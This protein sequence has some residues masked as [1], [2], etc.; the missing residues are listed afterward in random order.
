MPSHQTSPSSVLAQLV[1]TV[2]CSSIFRAFGLVCSPVPGATPKKPASGLTA[3]SRPSEP[4]FIHA[5]SSP[6]VSTFHPGRVGDHHRQVGLAACAG[7]RAGD[8]LRLALGRG[9]LE[10]QH[11][12]RE[13]ALVAR[14]DRGDPQCEALLAEQRVATVSRP[15][16][17][18]L[19]GLRE[20]HDVFVLGVA[21]PRHVLLAVGQRCA[22]GVQT[23]H[24][25]AIVAEHV[26]GVLPHPGHDPH[27]SRDVRRVGQLHA[28]IGDR[29]SERAHR[30]RHHVHGPPPHRPLEQL[31][32]RLAHLLGIAPVVRRPGVLLA[33]GADE[34][35]V[36]DARHVG[37][38]RQRQVGPGARVVGQT[39]ERPRRH[40][41][42]GQLLVLL[43]GPVA[44]V[45]V[46]GLCQ[47]GDL[48]YPLP[49]AHVVRGGLTLR[50]GM[51]HGNSA[52]PSVRWVIK[53]TLAK[54]NMARR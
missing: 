17:P 16:R 51:G 2:S 4:N 54:A 45:H 12:L 11:V 38:I 14:H 30:E 41:R 27:R 39:L 31:G 25:V 33:L 42:L 35:P 8:V 20:V 26:E 21:R 23:G 7:E 34:R 44:P 13:P 52:T 47:R 15:V 53:R 49:Q 36:L 46:V 19:A 1:N 6:T 48:V 9:H 5:M 24:E 28:D 22:D 37:R 10:D 18:D 29:R 43:V 32:Q 50:C 3:Y 40:Q